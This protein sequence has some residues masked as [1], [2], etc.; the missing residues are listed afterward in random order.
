MQK[1]F[2]YAV[3]V[4]GGSA[5]VGPV[6]SEANAVASE[7]TLEA[8][9]PTR[10]GRLACR[11]FFDSASALDRRLSL[12]Q[13]YAAKL[14][15][16]GGSIR[17]FDHIQPNEIPATG[18][19]ADARR[20]FDQGVALVYGFNHK[21]AIRSFAQAARIDPSCAMC[22]WG[23]ALANGPN[24]NAGMDDAANLAALAALER[25]E[26]MGEGLSPLERSLIAAQ[27]LRY[28]ASSE[29]ERAS[30]DAQYADA[31]LGLA[32]ANP[33]NDD[34]HIL[35]A[36]AAMNT[37]PWDY[38][39]ED[40]QAQPRIGEAV[41]LIETVIARNPQHP[42]A[43]H[44]YIHL[45]EN[46]PDPKIAEA[47]ADELARSGPTSLGHLVHMPAHIYYRIGRY[48]DSMKANTAA[49]RA[50]EQ[51]LA[52][53]GDDG[54]YRYGYYPH[55]VHFLL[56]SAQMVGN[57]HS[58]ASETERLKSILNDD[59]AK[60]LPWVQAIHA[61]PA[62]ALAQSGSPQAILALTKDSTDLAYVEAMRHYARAVG[63]ALAGDKAAFE[64]E[65]AALDTAGASAELAAMAEQGFPAPDIVKLASH[66]ARGR[67]ALANG[68]PGAAVGE[69]E[70][71]EAI[72]A[73]IPYNEPPYWYYPVAQSRGAALY[74]MGRHKEASAAFRKA[75][76]LAPNNGWALY[77][78]ARSEAKAGHNL[79]AKAARAK[80]EEV[81]QGETGWLDMK[82]L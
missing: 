8:L 79:E 63:Q 56:T 67:F 20:Y 82:R 12:A 27:K 37:R 80:L 42:Q 19:S 24:I 64:T 4:A 1:S 17:L 31:M 73:T 10:P 65:I 77:G 78:L 53:A 52:I 46:G 74:A 51:Y 76:F 61:A 54:L 28:S 23:I 22:W 48:A 5:I 15:A 68:N 81:W 35:A 75:L 3:L 47:A 38:W 60:Q 39:T 72:E 70:K 7:A 66:V 59:V 21:A 29:A 6:A 14:G 49:A 69:F 33:A 55:N 18:L 40:K 34:L 16:S 36:E 71:A 50:D 32:K 58:V 44:L 30:L 57:L 41:S 2:V 26:Q 25:A 11:G 62:F 13:D 43:S 45:M 9:D